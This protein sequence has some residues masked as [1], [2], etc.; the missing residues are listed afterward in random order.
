MFPAGKC[1]MSEGSRILS[2]GSQA[3]S[4]GK[5]AKPA[6]CRPVS[7]RR[8]LVPPR[9]GPFSA[10]KWPPPALLM[11]SLWEVADTPQEMAGSRQ[12]T[13]SAQ[14]EN[15]YLFSANGAASTLA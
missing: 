7:V 3:L 14:R 9:K 10:R 15:L 1:E 4:T 8:L 12:E 6:R 13:P 11:I 5:C 2:E